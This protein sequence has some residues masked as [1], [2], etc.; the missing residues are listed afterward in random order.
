[1]RKAISQTFPRD[2]GGCTIDD[3]ISAF[4]TVVDVLPKKKTSFFAS[5]SIE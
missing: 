2:V 4:E 5:V 3:E 1:L